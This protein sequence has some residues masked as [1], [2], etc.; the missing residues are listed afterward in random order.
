MTIACGR[1]RVSRSWD[2]DIILSSQCHLS[3]SMRGHPALILAM[4]S[5]GCRSSPSMKGKCLDSAIALPIVDF[6]HPAGPA[7]INKGILPRETENVILRQNAR[8]ARSQ[9]QL[10]GSELLQVDC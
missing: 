9:K 6:P 7:M 2:A 8:I 1:S 3:A 10:S 4:F 5:G